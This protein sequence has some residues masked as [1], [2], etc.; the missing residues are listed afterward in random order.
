MDVVEGTI[1]K[2]VV[3]I[4]PIGNITLSQCDFRAIFSTYGHTPI[5]ID[6]RDAVKQSD[7]S[8][9]FVVDTA[10]VGH[11]ELDC[12]LVVWIPDAD[13]PGMLRPEVLILNPQI[14]IVKSKW[15][16]LLKR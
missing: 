7:D 14:T 13:V 2:L 11:G 16:E 12:Q 6:K 5:V 1:K 15:N 10:K 4:E 3:T 8:Y 9:M